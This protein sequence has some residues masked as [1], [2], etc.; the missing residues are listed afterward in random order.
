MADEVVAGSGPVDA[1]QD[2]APEPGGDLPEGRGEHLLVVGER[3]RPGV[4][5]AQQ[6]VQA[7]AGVRAPGG[8]GVEAVA[9]L[10]GRGGSLLVGVG[11]DEGGVH[12][13][14][15][16]A[17]QRLARDGQPREPG[18]GRL[19][20]LPGV[21][22]GLRPRPGDPVEH[23]RGAGQVQGAADRGAAGRVPEHGGE[24]GEQGDV[25]HAGRP[26]R[27]RDGQRREHGPAVEQRRRALPQQGGA[28]SCGEPELVGGLAEQDGARVA[29]QPFPVR[30]D[31]QGMVPPV[32]LHGE[33]RSRLE[34]TC[35]W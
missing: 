10:P 27:D 24:V 33:E 18:R 8:E 35:V 26:E 25:A 30:G 6:H 20:Q 4:A 14:D 3:V 19:D 7:L 29:D 34:V 13:D 16:P 22:P 21:L 15:Q 31:L 1:D 23:G 17:G 28:Q 12:V 11:G 2:L 5:G 9:L 32:M